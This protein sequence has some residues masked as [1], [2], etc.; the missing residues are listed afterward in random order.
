MES[1]FSV[2]VRHHVVHEYNVIGIFRAFSEAFLTRFGLV[3]GNFILLH[4]RAQDDSVHVVVVHNK[5]LCAGS[6]EN[7][8][9]FLFLV[10]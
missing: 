6:F 5:H 2:H 1:L 10:A 9:D 7:L 8:A 3:Y 4:E